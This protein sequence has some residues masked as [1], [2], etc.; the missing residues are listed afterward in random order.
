VRNYTEELGKPHY[1]L[2]PEN[3]PLTPPVEGSWPITTMNEILWQTPDGNRLVMSDGTEFF[4]LQDGT[5]YVYGRRVLGD[6]T[7]LDKGSALVSWHIPSSV[8]DLYRIA[9]LDVGGGMTSVSRLLEGS[10]V[11]TL[12]WWS[13]KED[14]AIISIVPEAPPDDSRAPVPGILNL[15]TGEYSPIIGPFVTD[16]RPY[17]PYGRTLVDAVQVGPFALVTGTNS[18]LRVRAAPSLSG[19]VLACMAD[20]VLLR[21]MEDT[22]DADGQAWAR[23]MTPGGVQGWA[24]AAY[25]ER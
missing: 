6:F 23:V 24:S 16:E 25:L 3:T 11:W 1:T 5:L 21:D 22:V 4:T 10:A 19:E 7:G 17:H 8:G 15:S 20:G 13:P 12:G 9:T 18:C 14:L 2:L